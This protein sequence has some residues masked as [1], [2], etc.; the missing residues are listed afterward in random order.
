MKQTT[1]RVLGI[2]AASALLIGAAGGVFAHGGYGPGWGG[3]HGM[4]GGPRGMGAYGGPGWMMGGDPAAYTDQRLTQLKTTLGITPEQEAAWNA[5]AE[6]V[7]ARAGI[8]AAHHEAM[9]GQGT[10]T[11]EQRLG[12]HEQGL[13][14]MQKVTAAT[15]DLYAALTPEQQAKADGILVGPRCAFR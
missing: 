14:Q 10:V 5:Y 7:Q 9:F 2:A 8:R 11:P 15:R 1:K 12:F 4:M 6:A 3:H 13:A